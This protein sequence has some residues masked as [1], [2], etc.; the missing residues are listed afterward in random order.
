MT[1]TMLVGAALQF[2]GR[3]ITPED[4][5]QAL[6]KSP[7][8][9]DNTHNLVGVKAHQYRQVWLVVIVPE[10]INARGM[11]LSRHGLLWQDLVEV[12]RV[13]SFS[14]G[15]TFNGHRSE[16]LS[17]AKTDGTL[18]DGEMRVEVHA[19]GSDDARLHLPV[20]GL[21]QSAIAA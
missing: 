21:E 8:W 11:L 6:V 19:V 15:L 14:A 5:Y 2:G 7:P 4:I 10:G 9:S 3:R 13:L 18:A 17:A 1:T 16:L 12:G 20:E